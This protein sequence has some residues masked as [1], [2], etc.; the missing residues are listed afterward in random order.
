[1]TREER[2]TREQERQRYRLYYLDIWGLKKAEKET[3]RGGTKHL[4]FPDLQSAEY[5]AQIFADDKNRDVVVIQY[6]VYDYTTHKY[7]IP[8]DRIISVWHPNEEEE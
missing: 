4:V 8:Y 6:R 2:L 1:M 5:E 7:D 3:T